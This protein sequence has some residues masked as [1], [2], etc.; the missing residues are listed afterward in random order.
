MEIY[1]I[2][3]GETY[4]NK[5]RLLQGRSDIELNENG[6]A[7]AGETGIALDDVNFDF[8][9]SSPLIRAYETA[10]LVRGHKNI[11]IIRDDRLMEIS[12]GDYEGKDSRELFQNTADPF[13]HF[14]ERPELYAP[15]PNGET[16]EAL[17]ERTKEFMQQVIEPLEESCKR[18]MITGHGA[19]NKSIEAYML[20]RDLKDYWENG[21]Q[22]N[23]SVFVVD[24]HNGQYNVIDE[25]KRISAT[26]KYK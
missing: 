6:R 21:L 13:H 11:Q 4:W 8:I 14:F 25:G 22:A 3:H 2:R 10:C 24:Y 1:L 19:M 23:C 5:H 9:Y 12:F 16:F 15:A 18:V 20:N 26:K 7:L 17:L